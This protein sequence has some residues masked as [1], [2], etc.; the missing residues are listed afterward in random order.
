MIVWCLGAVWSS[1]LGLTN[2]SLDESCVGGDDGGEWG[3]KF[4]TWWDEWDEDVVSYVLFAFV[5]RINSKMSGSFWN[6][7]LFFCFWP[8]VL[9]GVNIV[10]FTRFLLLRL[11]MFLKWWTV[12]TKWLQM[13]LVSP[14]FLSVWA[15]NDIRASSFQYFFHCPCQPFQLY[16][17]LFLWK[18]SNLFFHL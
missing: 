4:C 9:K 13:S 5:L 12:M 7:T 15:F 14:I 2:F 18:E 6:V 17:V 16:A 3:E 8:G 11:W 1:A 10:T